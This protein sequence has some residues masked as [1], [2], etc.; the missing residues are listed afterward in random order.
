MYTNNFKSLLS[1]YILYPWTRART[2][3]YG[4]DSDNYALNFISYEG[5]SYSTSGYPNSTMQ[6]NVM[7][8]RVYLNG[9]RKIIF[10]NVTTSDI[11]SSTGYGDMNMMIIPGGGS[12]TAESP[13]N[14]NLDIPYTLNDFSFVGGKVV[15]TDTGYIY[16]STLQNITNHNIAVSELGLYMKGSTIR[17]W[18]NRD[19][20]CILLN[21]EVLD[22]VITIPPNGIYT[23]SLELKFNGFT[24]NFINAMTKV[25]LYNQGIETVTIAATDYAGSVYDTLSFTYSNTMTSSAL[26][27]GFRTMSANATFTTD[28]SGGYGNGIIFMRCGSGTSAVTL[29]DYNLE[30]PINNSTENAALTEPIS[31]GLDGIAASFSTNNNISYTVTFKNNLAESVTINEI[32]LFTRYYGGI[33]MMLY[34]EVLPNSITLASGDTTTITIS[35]LSN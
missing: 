34:R 1:N 31:G 12:T 30:S 5:N 6:Y 20:H 15:Q 33:C 27:R 4:N 25:L 19:Y 26:A 14:Y 29:G 16:L 3:S 22:S 32:G 24:K 18:S 13:S 21:R 9:F 11:S 23:F 8:N 2:D 7:Y 28:P 10:E 17:K 35:I